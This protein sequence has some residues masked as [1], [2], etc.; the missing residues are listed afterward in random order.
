MSEHCTVPA[1]QAVFSDDDYEF[2]QGAISADMHGVHFQYLPGLRAVLE[3]RPGVA[4]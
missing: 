3:P 2:I 4:A 1:P